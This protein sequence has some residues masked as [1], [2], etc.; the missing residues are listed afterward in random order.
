[1]GMTQG[2][3]DGPLAGNCVGICAAATVAVLLPLR[4]NLKSRT[5]FGVLAALASD[6]ACLLLLPAACCLLPAACCRQNP[7]KLAQFGQCPATRA[8]AEFTGNQ[9]FEDVCCTACCPPWWAS[10]I[11]KRRWSAPAFLI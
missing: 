11:C 7:Q 8:M 9:P 5:P 1:M 4:F 2:S 3:S 10:R 6:A